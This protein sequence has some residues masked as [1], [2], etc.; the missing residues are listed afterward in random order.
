MGAVSFVTVDATGTLGQGSVDLSGLIAGQVVQDNR[1]TSVE[2]VNGLQDGRLTSVE[3][4]NAVQDTRLTSVESV[5]AVQTVQLGALQSSSSMQATQ[6]TSI[7]GLNATQ[8]TRLTSLEAFNFNHAGR[9]TFL[10]EGQ[11]Q[12]FNLADVNRKQANRGI[13]AAVALADAPFPSAPGVTSYAANA[14][15]YRGQMATSVSFMHRLDT[16]KPFAF[17]GAVSYA[18]KGDVA[19]RVGVAGEF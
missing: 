10:E 8:D 7:Q 18:G 2:A 12:L 16:A 15:M 3:A 1:L 19:A 6:I 13:A 9:L 4:V 17:T 11:A 5:N 14:A